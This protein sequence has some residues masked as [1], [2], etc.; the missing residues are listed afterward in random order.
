[1]V[2][3][4][5]LAAV[6]GAHR[7]D[8]ILFAAGDGIARSGRREGLRIEDLA[9]TIMYLLALPVPREMDGRVL[10]EVIDAAVLSAD[11]I[12]QSDDELAATSVERRLTASEEQEVRQQLEGLGYV[13]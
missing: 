11:P 8:G 3:R 10:D 6:K 1:V 4:V 7:F 2:D 12:R 13:D 5:E 9:P